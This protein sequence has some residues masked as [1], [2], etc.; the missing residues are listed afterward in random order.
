MTP[1]TKEQMQKLSPG[2]QADLAVLELQRAKKRHRLL[3]Q[4]RG[5]RGQNIVPGVLMGIVLSVFLFSAKDSPVHSMLLFTGLNSLLLLT[6]FH[7]A[8]I[9][10]RLDAL[11]ELLEDELQNAAQITKSGGGKDAQLSEPQ[12]SL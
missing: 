8:L 4:A 10:R 1:L 7:A 11:M 3:E 5:Y 2:Q 6:M 12:Q 9:N